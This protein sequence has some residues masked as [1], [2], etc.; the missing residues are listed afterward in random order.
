VDI[1]ACVTTGATTIMMEGDYSMRLTLKRFR[2]INWPLIGGIIAAVV[3]AA[4]PIFFLLRRRI[5]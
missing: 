5:V 3:A 1:I 2:P 4:L